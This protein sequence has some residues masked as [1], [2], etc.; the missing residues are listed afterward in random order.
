[1]SGNTISASDVFVSMLPGQRT[2]LSAAVG[3]C[4]VQVHYGNIV[5]ERTRAVVNSVGASNY[6]GTYQIF[7]LKIIEIIIL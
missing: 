2:G 4:R 1:M 6:G 5:E 7:A 3:R